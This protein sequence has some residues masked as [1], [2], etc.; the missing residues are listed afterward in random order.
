MDVIVLSFA[1][2]GVL[3]VWLI[4]LTAL[5][6]KEKQFLKDLS[7]GSA[8]KD[9]TSILRQLNTSIKLA[10]VKLEQTSNRIDNIESADKLHFQ[11]IGFVRFNP[12]SDTGGDQSFSL[13]LLDQNNNGIVITSL[14]SR[15][16]TRLYAKELKSAHLNQADYSEEEWKAYQTAKNYQ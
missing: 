12:F 6:A 8:K 4:V 3:V 16:S 14:H 10:S 7:K 2:S 1:V 9:L 11:K 15:N 5:V 13:C